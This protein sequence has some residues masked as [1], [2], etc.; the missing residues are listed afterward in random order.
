MIHDKLSTLAFKSLLKV[1][2]VFCVFFLIDEPRE[3]K[4]A[5]KPEKSSA[6]TN[7]VPPGVVV[8]GSKRNMCFPVRRP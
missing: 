2:K 8:L 5:N 1:S 4:I 3:N 6:C 7:L